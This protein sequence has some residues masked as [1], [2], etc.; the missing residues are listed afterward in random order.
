[1]ICGLLAAFVRRFI[2]ARPAAE[3]GNGFRNHPGTGVHRRK[4]N[5][6]LRGDGFAGATGAEVEQWSGA[7]AVLGL[8]PR[9]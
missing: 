9:M 1:M 6:C 8:V 7:D 5:G 3:A 4:L 2:H